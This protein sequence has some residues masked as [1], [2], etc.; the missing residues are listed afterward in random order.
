MQGDVYGLSMVHKKLIIATKMAFHVI[1][2]TFYLVSRISQQCRLIQY[3]IAIPATVIAE[4]YYALPLPLTP[5][6][7][8]KKYLDYFFKIQDC[9]PSVTLLHYHVH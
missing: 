2:C 1:S 5:T 4:V 6:T 9:F 7:T 8:V 3:P